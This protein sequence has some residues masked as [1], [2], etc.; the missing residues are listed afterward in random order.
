MNITHYGLNDRDHILVYQKCLLERNI[1]KNSSHDP[2]MSTRSLG[3]N[4][5]AF[6]VKR[7]DGVKLLVILDADDG[8]G[9]TPADCKITWSILR[10]IQLKYVP[11]DMMILKSQVNRNPEYNQFYPF[12]EDVYPI[13]IFSND[14][15]EVFRR[16]EVYKKVEQEDI[17]VFFAGGRKHS[18]VRPYTWPKNR[19]IKKWWPGVA[20]RGY[21]KLLNL[22]NKRQDIKFALF[23]ESLPADQFY[24]LMRR[25]K[26]CV[27]LPGIGLS[28]RKFYEY[29]V[30]GKCVLSLRQQ[31]TSWDCEENVHYCSMEEELDFD[32]LEEKIDFLL[33]NS[34]FRNTI[35]KNVANISAQL[36]LESLIQKAEC[37]IKEKLNLMSEKHILCY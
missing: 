33:S 6:I 32:S 35:E 36:T 29:L 28:S 18:K 23:D 9:G 12:K 1:G 16:R 24:S 10:E 3:K 17:D 22:R 2:L 8:S 15:H 4:L 37:A 26:I 25:S 13:G 27:D 34:Q 14:P 31:Y 20:Y 7:E 11:H 19:D 5:S 30:F 21:E